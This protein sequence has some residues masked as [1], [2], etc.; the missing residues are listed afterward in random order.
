MGFN[1]NVVPTDET[2]AG[3]GALTFNPTNT[4]PNGSITYFIYK[5]PNTSVPLATTTNPSIGGLGAGNYRVIAKE[6]VNG[7]ETTQTQDVTINNA[8]VPLTYTIQSL[9]QACS[10][11]SNATVTVVTGVAVSYQIISGP[12]QFP[13][14]ASNTFSGLPLGTYTFL[15]TDSCGGGKTQTYTV[16]NNPAG[17]TIAPPLFNNT[18]PPSC[19][20]TVA[21]N[22]VSA[23]AGTVIGYPL[24][25]QYTVHPPIGANIVYNNSIANGAAQSQ[26][27]SQTIPY[28]VNQSYSYDIAITD[29][30]GTTVTMNFPVNL[31]ITLSPTIINLNCNNHYFEL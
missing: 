26:N 18:T 20:F 28:Y 5:L 16:S 8:I 15:V 22:L 6:T 9:N 29:A 25:V 4:D 31:D 1:I 14:Q 2:C 24:T 3:N 12:M 17:L 30:C 23:A 19:A 27:L 13:A 10:T 11:T 7:V 21:N